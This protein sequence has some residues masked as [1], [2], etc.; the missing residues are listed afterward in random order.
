MEERL[1]AKRTGTC[2]PV[3]KTNSTVKTFHTLTY[4]HIQTANRA[5]VH[6]L[7][8]LPEGLGRCVLKCDLRCS[9]LLHGAV[10]KAFKVLGLGGE[11]GTMGHDW[12]LPAD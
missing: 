3:L 10:E 9:S 12:H 4:H 7:E 8:Q 2:V 1:R 6:K 11:D 5:R